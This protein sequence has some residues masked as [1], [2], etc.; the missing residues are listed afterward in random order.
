MVMHDLDRTQQFVESGSME[1]EADNEFGF[2][3]SQEMEGEVN[4][5][6]E[7]ELATELL[8]VNNEEELEEFIGD[9]FK[10]VVKGVKNFANSSTGKALGGMLKGV[11]KK[12]LPVVGGALGSVIAPGV[13]TAI[14]SS[15]GGAAGNALGLELEGLSSED[16]E[17]EVSKTLVRL[18]T[19]AARSAADS[20]GA[21]RRSDD[22]RPG[23][24]PRGRGLS[25]A[26]I[27]EL[28]FREFR[29]GAPWHFLFIRRRPG[30]SPPSAYRPVGAAWIDDR[31]LRGVRGGWRPVTHGADGCTPNRRTT[32]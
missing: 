1:L 4:E 2:E 32:S 24:H 28:F 21:G 31:A 7:M 15:L 20:A 18:A 9:L 30:A 29:P 25:C 26:G 27:A 16:Q 19:E 14:G 17:L 13:G 6:T 3:M 23:S 22:D 8:S 5:D 12:A 10:K 11:V